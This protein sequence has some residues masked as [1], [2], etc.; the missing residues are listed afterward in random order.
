MDNWNHNERVHK[1]YRV[2]SILLFDSG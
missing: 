2:Y 1:S